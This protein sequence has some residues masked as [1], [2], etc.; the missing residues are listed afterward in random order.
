[1]AKPRK[2]H[3]QA[4]KKKLQVKQSQKQTAEAVTAATKGIDGSVS[5]SKLSPASKAAQQPVPAEAAGSEQTIYGLTNLGNTCFYNSAMQV[6]HCMCMSLCTCTLSSLPLLVWCTWESCV[7][8]NPFQDHMRSDTP[9]IVWFFCVQVLVSVPAL[10]DFCTQPHSGP[11]LQKGP[12]GG[13]LQELVQTVY[14]AQCSLPI[15]ACSIR[16]ASCKFTVLR[17]TS[18]EQATWLLLLLWACLLLEVVWCNQENWKNW[19]PWGAKCSV[20]FM[21]AVTEH[22]RPANFG[23]EQDICDVL[24][25]GH[26]GA[27][28]AH[29][30]K[31][32][33]VSRREGT[34]QFSPSRLFA[35]VCRIAPQ[36]K[37]SSHAKPST[38]HWWQSAPPIPL[39]WICCIR[40][41]RVEVGT[42]R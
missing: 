1:M 8:K 17:I 19:E 13:A 41:H 37:V 39:P 2:Q 34:P 5:T 26:R 24:E 38:A 35:A 7:F 12:I 33:K 29:N 21:L 42:L 20:G 14:G 23:W 4:S 32:A 15:S 25:T 9:V 28:Q 40:K 11:Q 3:Q 22:S 6:Q 31:A 36:F 16:S 30:P 18:V 27:E 10:K